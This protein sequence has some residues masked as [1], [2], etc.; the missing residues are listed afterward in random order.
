MLS[1]VKKNKGVTLVEVMVVVFIFGFF[2]VGMVNAYIYGLKLFKSTVTMNLMYS[3]GMM[4]L[5]KIENMIRNAENINIF[6]S[7]ANPRME[8]VVPERSSAAG[9]VEFYVNHS[10]KSLR[11]NDRRVNHGEFN[12]RLLP[13]TTYASRRRA[14]QAYKMK[15]VKFEY[16]EDVTGGITDP[17][18]MMVRVTIVL[19]NPEGDTLALRATTLNRNYAN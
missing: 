7:D 8:L 5:R 1:R 6:E 4:V 2:T 17:Q 14:V 13:A 3:D 9:P 12:V 18:Q 11:M 10:D 19:E 15:R 16:A